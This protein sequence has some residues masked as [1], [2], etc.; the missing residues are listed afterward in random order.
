MNLFVVMADP[1][2]GKDELVTPPL[3]GTILPGIIRDSVLALARERLKDH[4]LISEREVTMDEVS[5]A[6]DQGRLREVFGTGTAAVV[7]PVRSI[8]WDGRLV[9][10]GLEEG[11]ETGPLAKKLKDWIESIQYGDL[12]HEWSYLIPG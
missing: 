4:L 10:C 5:R 9:N 6:S 3:D 7:L 11:N 8:G 2:T 12:Q 1:V